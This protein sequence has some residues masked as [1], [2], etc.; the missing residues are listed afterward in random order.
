M[1]YLFCA[2]LGRVQTIGYQQLLD[3]G[4]FNE[5]KAKEQLRSEGKEYVV[6]EGY[7]MEFL[8]NV[9]KA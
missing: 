1:R 4:S 9:D 8:F 3:A 5:A 6:V 2:R 7:V